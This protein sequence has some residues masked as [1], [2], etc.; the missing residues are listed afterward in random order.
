MQYI[1]FSHIL[2]CHEGKMG[3]SGLIKVTEALRMLDMAVQLMLWMKT[4]K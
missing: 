3:I 1:Y 2:T 4:W